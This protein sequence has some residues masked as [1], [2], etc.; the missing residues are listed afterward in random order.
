[1]FDKITALLY[2]NVTKLPL[3]KTLRGA[4]FENEYSYEEVCADSIIPHLLR[5]H[6]LPII[7]TGRRYG[8]DQHEVYQVHIRSVDGR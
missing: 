7:S 3:E 6:P 5:P 2:E 8:R 1:M 4:C